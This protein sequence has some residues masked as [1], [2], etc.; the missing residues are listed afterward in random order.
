MSGLVAGF[1][2]FTLQ[3]LPEIAGAGIGV[4]GGFQADRF[5][6]RRR[7][8]RQEEAE[9][10]ELEKIIDDFLDDAKANADAAE[11]LG[12]TP[13]TEL[14]R[15]TDGLRVA[16][17]EANKER[18]FELC[19][20]AIIRKSYAMFFEEVKQLRRLIDQAREYGME[21]RRNFWQD[22][23]DKVETM[24]RSLDSLHEE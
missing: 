20:D 11:E 9:E 10:R 22:Q 1:V 5:L 12:R 18:F 14:R 3:A 21:R 24:G 4:F 6:Q 16:G 23:A 7:E 15:Q 8:Q 17:W 13:H 2:D 19:D